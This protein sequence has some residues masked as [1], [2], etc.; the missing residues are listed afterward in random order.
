MPNIIRTATIAAPAE[1]VFGY[2]DDIRNLARHMSESRS[3]PMM[4]SKLK[5]EILTSNAT[6]VGATYQYSGS[7]MGLM[8]DFSET[9]TKYV[10]GREKIWRTIGNPQLLIVESYEM[11]VVVEPLQAN[12]A[13]L[14][15]SFDYDLPRSGMWR[16][17][18]R[19]LAG[20]Y[21]RW[22]LDSM[23]SG[24]KRDLERSAP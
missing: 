8:I 12:T 15:I 9:V 2:V 7:M 14:T 1:R 4:G 24:T 5:L 11:R 20:S 23:I 18:G 16:L 21:A 6:D 10:S 3:M 13:Q 19:A 17:I 22:C